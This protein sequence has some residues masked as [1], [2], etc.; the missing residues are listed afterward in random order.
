MKLL[1]SENVQL[2]K[3]NSK[4]KWMAKWWRVN[5]IKKN[6]KKDK[7]NLMKMKNNMKKMASNEREFI[8]IRLILHQ[9]TPFRS[10]KDDIKF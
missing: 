8:N 6:N 2:K 5:M 10:T 1:Y 9:Q 7:T 3:M 4:K